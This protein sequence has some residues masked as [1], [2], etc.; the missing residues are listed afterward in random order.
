MQTTTPINKKPLEYHVI[1]NLS[2]CFQSNKS[3][4]YQ[5]FMP[6]IKNSYNLVNK[7]NDYDG[8]TSTVKSEITSWQ[9]SRWKLLNASSSIL[10]DLIKKI[11]YPLRKPQNDYVKHKH[12]QKKRSIEKILSKFKEQN[13]GINFINI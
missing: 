1:T 7:K 12:F 3:K 13:A 11:L 2:P 10:D 6:P 4:T 5:T 8:E 9:N